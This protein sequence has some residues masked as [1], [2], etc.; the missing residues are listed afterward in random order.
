MFVILL[1][2]MAMAVSATAAD[3]PAWPLGLETRYLTGN[4]MEPRDGR[5]HTGLDLKTNSRTGYPVIA[6]RGG[7]V[8]RVRCSI[9]GYGKAV[10]LV[11]DDGLTYVYAHL[12][13]L[14]DDLR[15]QVRAEQVRQGRY[16]VDLH[17]GPA[18]FPVRRGEVIALSGQTATLGPHLHFEVRGP[19]GLPRDPLAHGFA[20]N[21]AL[22]PEILAVRLVDPSGE[23]GCSLVT[24][25]GRTP[26]AGELPAVTVPHGDI[27]FSARIVERSDHLRYRLGAWRIRL[28]CDGWTILDARNDALDWRHNRQQR[29]EFVETGLGRERWL[30][31]DPR[32]ELGGRTKAGEVRLGPGDH[33]YTLTVE[34]R[35]G[36]RSSVSWT[37]RIA[38]ADGGAAWSGWSRDAAPLPEPWLVAAVEEGDCPAPGDAPRLIWRRGPLQEALPPRWWRV[39]GLEPVGDPVQFRAEGGAL[40]E[41]VM[42]AWPDSA[43]VAGADASVAVYRLDGDEWTWETALDGGAF[44]LDRAGVHALLRDQAPPVIATAV[45]DTVLSAA[46]REVRHGVTLA[47]WPLLR[48]P[49]GDHGSGVDWS[50]VEVRL[51]SEPLIAE[52]DAPRDRILVEL[53]DATPPGAHRLDILARD[54][55][56]HQAEATIRLHLRGRGVEDAEAP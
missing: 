29:L 3:P 31:Q 38:A 17:F 45:V 37:L 50:A 35:S 21:D 46:A 34:D 30:W 28:E 5:F 36:N 22:A 14:A 20:V 18:R 56:G 41:A 11:G 26:L 6:A 27:R 51:D 47:R 7:D 39:A 49:V 48:V 2:A 42:T 25:D 24:G 1:L 9:N 8:A 4:F 55:G 23:A 44:L 32:V 19:D 13:R 40:V 15:A 12:D 53:P 10:Y 54:R 43:A 33:R 16:E 52:P